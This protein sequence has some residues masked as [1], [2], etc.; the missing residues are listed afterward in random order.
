MYLFYCKN[1]NDIKKVAIQIFTIESEISVDEA[2]LKS[3]IYNCIYKNEGQLDCCDDCEDLCE[4]CQNLSNK[5]VY[6]NIEILEPK[7]EYP[8]IAVYD[9]DSDECLKYF[10]VNDIKDNTKYGITNRNGF[11]F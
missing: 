9:R 10:S 2:I 4:L 6:K 8:L 11:Y 7:I 1:E 3:K 5:D